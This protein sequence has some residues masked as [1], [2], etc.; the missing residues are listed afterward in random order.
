MDDRVGE[1]DARVQDLVSLRT[2][3]FGLLWSG[4]VE[5]LKWPRAYQ[6]FDDDSE[7]PEFE[8]A[9]EELERTLRRAM[10]C[11]RRSRFVVA[12]CGMVNAGTSGDS[13]I[14]W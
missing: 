10:V 14:R 3:L 13:P 5:Q 2:S 9:V 11:S 8:N 4:T 1:Y 6:P 7:R 12:F